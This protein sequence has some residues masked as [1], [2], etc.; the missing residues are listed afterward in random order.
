MQTAQYH[1]F[2]TLDKSIDNLDGWSNL[3]NICM[4]YAKTFSAARSG[5]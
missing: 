5:H 1:Q 2:C 3:K 4:H